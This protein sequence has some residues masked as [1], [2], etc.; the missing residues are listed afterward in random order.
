MQAEKPP[1][2][3]ARGRGEDAA[4]TK[5]ASGPSG[6]GDEALVTFPP[7]TWDPDCVQPSQDPQLSGLSMLASPQ[8]PEAG[9]PCPLGTGAS[10]A[11]SE[12][13]LE[14]TERS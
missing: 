4:P 5:V 10:E 3:L 12:L 13:E 7:P 11:G 6:L 14:V 2:L 8:G 9:R 1:S